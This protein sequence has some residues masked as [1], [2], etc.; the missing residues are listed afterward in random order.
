VLV[1]H[2][3]SYV[4]MDTFEMVEPAS[5][6]LVAVAVVVA[7]ALVVGLVDMVPSEPVVHQIVD[8]EWRRF[9]DLV[10]NLVEA[11]R[12]GGFAVEQSLEMHCPE[13]ELVVDL[14]VGLDPGPDPDMRSLGMLVAGS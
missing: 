9:A 5:S 6:F 8:A 3:G 1:H 7:C 2:Y 11:D 12:E 14:V 10:V 13:P 4:W